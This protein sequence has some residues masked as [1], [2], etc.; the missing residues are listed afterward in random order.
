LLQQNLANQAADPPREVAE[1]SEKSFT[2]TDDVNGD[3]ISMSK[4]VQ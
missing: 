2:Q 4:S 3:N 1:N